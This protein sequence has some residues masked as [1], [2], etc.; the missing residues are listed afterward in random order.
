MVGRRPLSSGF[1][2]FAVDRRATAAR[3]DTLSSPAA[4]SPQGRPRAPDS[5][6]P[7]PGLSSGQS[8]RPRP[9]GKP[10]P[11]R[12]YVGH[13]PTMPSWGLAGLSA[14]DVDAVA[15]YIEGHLRPPEQTDGD[16]AGAE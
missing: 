8:V 9:A 3:N 6:R 7:S 10:C 13:G 12:I 16:T 11:D 5:V 4:L 1:V 2:V 14:R 15:C